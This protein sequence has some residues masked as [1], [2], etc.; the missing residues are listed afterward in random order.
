MDRPPLPASAR[1]PHP[2]RLDPKRPDY[3]LIL[4][5]HEKALADRDMAV[6]L[7]PAD[8][9]AYVARGGS[10]HQLGKHDQGL[11]DRSRA[12][13]LDPKNATAWLARANAYFLMGRWQDATADLKET[14]RLNP[15]VTDLFAFDYDDIEILGYDPHPAIKAPVAV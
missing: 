13:E 3:R 1:T 14:L 15:D 6:K 11:A 2:S 5:S 12:I 7:D 9:A 4:S 10:Y 8:S